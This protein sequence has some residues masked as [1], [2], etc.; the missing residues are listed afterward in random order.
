MRKLMGSMCQ[1]HPLQIRQRSIALGSDVSTFLHA[2]AEPDVL[3]RAQPAKE[4]R[5]LKHVTQLVVLGRSPLPVNFNGPLFRL[6]ESRQ[7]VKQGALAAAG[8]PEQH[9]KFAL[10]RMETEIAEHRCAAGVTK[11]DIVYRQCG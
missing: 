7:Q 10:P 3:Q 8:R 1:S 11:S 2:Q 9:N 5:L 4:L 6:G